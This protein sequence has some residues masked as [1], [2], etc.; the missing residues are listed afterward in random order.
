MGGSS[1]SQRFSQFDWLPKY[2]I[3]TTRGNAVFCGNHLPS[4]ICWNEDVF[5]MRAKSCPGLLELERLMRI[6]QEVDLTDF[7]IKHGSKYG[8]RAVQV[9]HLEDYVIP[10]QYLN[11]YCMLQGVVVE[12]P[13]EVRIHIERHQITKM[14]C[15]VND[16]FG[17][18]ICHDGAEPWTYC[19]PDIYDKRCQHYPGLVELHRLILRQNNPDELYSFESKYGHK[20]GGPEAQAKCLNKFHIP[21]IYIRDKYSFSKIVLSDPLQ[22]HE[23]YKK[24]YLTFSNYDGPEELSAGSFNGFGRHGNHET[25]S[26]DGREDKSALDTE[27]AVNAAVLHT[28]LD[29]YDKDHHL[30]K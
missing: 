18:H 30:R 28:F 22:T 6:Y 12:G 7:E 15:F 27:I 10:W 26:S 8:G 13:F 24:T 4:K 20:Y 29:M 11:P 3:R 14:S 2:F 5:D 21:T 19:D 16:Q 9:Q 17:R 1:S 25:K 23:D